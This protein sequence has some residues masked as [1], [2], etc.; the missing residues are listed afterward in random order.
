MAHNAL[1]RGGTGSG[2]W[3]AVTVTAGDWETFDQ[4]QFESINGDLGGTWAP[5][6]V[7][8]IGGV[9]LTVTSTL[10]GS[11]TNT[12]SGTTTTGVLNVHGQSTVWNKMTIDGAN[13]GESYYTSGALLTGVAGST[14]NWAGAMNISGVTTLTNDASITGAG[15]KFTFDTSADA[16]DFKNGFTVTAGTANFNNATT[17][18]G[19]TLNLSAVMNIQSSAH[20][21]W[22]RIDG[23]NA[24][25][26]YGIAD[27]DHISTNPSAA[28]NYTM[29]NTGCTGGEVISIFNESSTAGR[30]I[31]IYQHNG[32][33]FIA[34]LLAVGP[35]FGGIEL[36]NDGTGSVS[37]AWRVRSITYKP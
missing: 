11:G 1:I 10:T 19:G 34:V 18:I 2:S 22:R 31:S 9:G 3:T 21:R 13:S 32:S 7:I 8:T 30:D 35:G 4:R 12:L 25:A 33:T 23:A 27:A 28:R 20:I 17:Q 14:A 29:S 6:A 16:P 5:A 26:T 24:N 15:N 37:A 36:I